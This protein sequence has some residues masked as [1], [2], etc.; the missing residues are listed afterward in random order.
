MS[1]IVHVDF[2]HPDPISALA[3]DLEGTCN[4]YE[5]SI[6]LTQKQLEKLDERVRCCDGCGWWCDTNEMVITDEQ[7]CQ[8]CA[9]E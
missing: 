1:D 9:D 7:N 4:N 3:D 6:E 2:N 5:S 8:D